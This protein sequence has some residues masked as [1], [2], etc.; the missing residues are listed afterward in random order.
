MIEILNPPL[1][2]IDC[3]V[4]DC[5][6]SIANALELLQSCTK[7]SIWGIFAM[8]QW[9]HIGTT[10]WW[11]APAMNNQWDQVMKTDTTMNIALFHQQLLVKRQVNYK[12]D[13]KIASSS[14]NRFVLVAIT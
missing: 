12:Y 5:N 2:Y 9:V 7:L 14:R 3:F 13:S 10:R 4:K 8:D 11:C 6:N 1:M